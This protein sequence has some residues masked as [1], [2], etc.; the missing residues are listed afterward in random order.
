[1]SDE[2]S[3]AAAASALSKPATVLIQKISKAVGILY[4]P[5]RIRKEA[6]AEADAAIIKAKAQV[7]VTEVQARG[8]LRLIHEEGRRQE[9]I[10]AITRLALPLLTD[11]A[12]PEAIEEDWIVN[13]FDQ[14]RRISD[15]EMQ[16]LWAK[17]LAGEANRPGTFSKRTVNMV[18]SLDKSDAVLFTNLCRC[19]VMFPGMTP[20]VFNLQDKIYTDLGLTFETLTHLDSIGL[21]KFQSLTGFIKQGLRQKGFLHYFGE[22]IYLEFS[23]ESDN[24]LP[25]GALLLTS[26]GEELAA[27][28]GAT[29]VPGFADYLRGKWNGHGIKTVMGQT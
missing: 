7:A 12:K 11:D 14:G 19:S 2:T 5:T 9:N 29:P 26:T 17:L 21:A 16:S 18:A 28:S 3:L 22:A 15:E 10:E 13:L 6:L 8:L 27:I 4:E 1:M 20:V 25:I 23:K 24:Q